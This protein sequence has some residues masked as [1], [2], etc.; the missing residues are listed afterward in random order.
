MSADLLKGRPTMQAQW[1]FPKAMEAEVLEWIA[2]HEKWMKETHQFGVLD[3]TPASGGPRMLE[4][5]FTFG[6]KMNEALDVSRNS[7][8][9]KIL[10]LTTHFIFP[11]SNACSPPKDSRTLLSLA[12][13]KLTL[14]LRT[15]RPTLQ[16]PVNPGQQA[17]RR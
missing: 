12:L 11:L 9:L 7:L 13:L 10:Q 15:S 6:T 16:W 3:G 2:S 1:E 17:S 14:G 8:E 4:Y 5:F